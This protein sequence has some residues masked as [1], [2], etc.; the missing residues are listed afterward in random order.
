MKLAL[1]SGDDVPGSSYNYYRPRQLREYVQ[2]LGQI[3]RNVDSLT[4]LGNAD[5]LQA[6]TTSTYE[7]EWRN[8]LVVTNRTSTHR[9]IYAFYEHEATSQSRYVPW[10]AEDVAESDI[11]WPC[12]KW[13]VSDCSA[14][15]LIANATNWVVRSPDGRH[16]DSV[17]YC[18]AEPFPPHCTVEVSIS[19]LAAVIVCNCIKITC[20]LLTVL[21]PHFQPLVTIG[22]AISSFLREP[23]PVT[24]GKGALEVADVTSGVWRKY[25]PILWVPQERCWRRAVAMPHW[26]LCIF[27]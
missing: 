9:N 20:L 21:S 6:Y 2:Q 13:S 5:C 25:A 1:F 26:Y 3:Q 23:D 18:L 14:P 4:R 15:S 27:L 19:L 16:H 12:D 22:D 11:L 7:F 17:E 10:A 24:A 8:V